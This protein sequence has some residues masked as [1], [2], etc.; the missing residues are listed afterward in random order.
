MPR[1]A[2]AAA[3]EFEIADGLRAAEKLNLDGLL[4]LWHPSVGN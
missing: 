3:H 1:R 4:M 2:A